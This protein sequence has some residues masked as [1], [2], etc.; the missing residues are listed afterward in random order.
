MERLHCR[1]ARIIFNP[2]KDLPSAMVLEHAKWTTLYFRYKLET[3]KIIHKAYN[4]RLP[5]ILKENIIQ[6]RS[7]RYSF[8]DRH[9]LV[10]PRFFT[11]VMKDLI[12]Y[13]GAVLWN[14][15]TYGDTVI[16]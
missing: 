9:S 3:F 1:A 10:V 7:Q 5:E 8:R 6:K 4:G 2:A 11:R 14:T 13:R 12:H 15:V 16:T